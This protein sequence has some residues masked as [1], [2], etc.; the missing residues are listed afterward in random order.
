MS[1]HI[2]SDTDKT[3]KPE[4]EKEALQWLLFADQSFAM[5]IYFRDMAHIGGW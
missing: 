5:V 3:Q 2:R 1:D 4:M